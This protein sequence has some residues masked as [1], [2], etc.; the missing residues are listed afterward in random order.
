[1]DTNGF[2]Q[3]NIEIDSIYH[4]KLCS[5]ELEQKKAREDRLLQEQKE[6][7]EYYQMLVRKYGK[8]NAKLIKEG[9]VR[10]GFT[11]EMCIEAWG[12]PEY[13]NTSTTANGKIEQWVDGWFSYLY[14][15]GNKLVTIQDQE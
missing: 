11:K 4:E 13:I 9:E 5:Q 2:K 7:Q 12:E 8:T 1:M 15:K 10:I 6:E 14:F 3:V